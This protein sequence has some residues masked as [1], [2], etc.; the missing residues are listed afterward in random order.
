MAIPPTSE[1]HRAQHHQKVQESTGQIGEHQK[2]RIQK[3]KLGNLSTHATTQN[4][5]L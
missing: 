4:D 3:M 2:W 1:H 5:V